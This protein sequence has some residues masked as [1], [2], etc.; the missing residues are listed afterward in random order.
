MPPRTVNFTK[1]MRLPN[2]SSDWK[3]M[4][5]TVRAGSNRATQ[6][7][8]TRTETRKVTHVIPARVCSSPRHAPAALP[9]NKVAHVLKGHG[10]EGA[11]DI[12][13]GL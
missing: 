11:G 5:A 1:P 2:L 8:H 13:A 12:H 9:G 7:L 4:R 3:W 6:S 10:A